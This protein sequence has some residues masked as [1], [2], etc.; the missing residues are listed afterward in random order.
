MGIPLIA[1][2]FAVLTAQEFLSIDKSV[3]CTHYLT[4]AHYHRMDMQ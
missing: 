3:R 2:L 1:F 4:H